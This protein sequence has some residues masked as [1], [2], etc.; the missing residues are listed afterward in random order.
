LIAVV[1]TGAWGTTLAVLLSRA[2]TDTSL[3]TRT[4]AEAERLRRDGE[5]ARFLAGIALPDTLHIGTAAQGMLSGRRIVLLVV[6]AQQMRANL[7]A[8]REFLDPDVTLVSAA[9]GLEMETCKRMSQVIAEEAGPA[10]SGRIAAISGPNLS[11]EVVRGLPTASVVAS[12]D[13][14]V[15]RLVQEELRLPNVRLYTNLDLV[16]VELAGALKNI[17]ALGAGACDGLGYGDNAKAAFMTRGLAEI[18]R[19]GVAMGANPLTF[20]GLAGIG[21]LM[22]TCASKLSRNRYVGEQ[23]GRG[24]SLAEV[25]AEMSQ[26]A[27]GV[28]T[29]AAAHRLA[30]RYGVDMPITATVFAVLFRGLTP[31]EGVGELMMRDQKGELTGFDLSERKGL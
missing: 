15:A 3:V 28:S 27:E 13:E 20:A 19:L 2:G 1:G 25:Q 17:I 10:V 30:Q 14:Q 22:A 8:L 7:V 21:D 16:G 23:I 29:A 5:N 24:R 31:R 11:G 4:P 12:R 6:P 18:A 26:V 9:K